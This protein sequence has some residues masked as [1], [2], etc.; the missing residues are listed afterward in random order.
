MALLHEVKID[1]DVWQLNPSLELIKEFRE[2]KEKEGYERSS[3]II[4][5]IFF[6]WDMKSDL[7]DSGMSE[8]KLMKDVSQ[9]L[10][11]DEDFNW[12]NYEDFK[13]FFLA[14]NLGKLESLFLEYE[15]DLED[16]NTFISTLKWGKTTIDTKAKANKQR[17]ELFDQLL[18]IREKLKHDGDVEADM[19]GGYVKSFIENFGTDE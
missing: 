7:R 6:I 1:S 10:L 16:L 14:A 12:Q 9:M 5:A 2:L 13:D 15:K 4:K 18:E 8:S 17:K 11:E 3:A 19:E